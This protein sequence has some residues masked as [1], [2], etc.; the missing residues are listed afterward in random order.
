MKQV[1]LLIALSLISAFG[2]AQDFQLDKDDDGPDFKRWDCIVDF[3]RGGSEAYMFNLSGIYGINFAG[4]HLFYGGGLSASYV[5]RP[6]ESFNYVG[7]FW[8]NG[9]EVR[10]NMTEVTSAGLSHGL[11]SLLMNFR[12][13]ILVRSQW[14]PILQFRMANAFGSRDTYLNQNIGFCYKFRNG[15]LLNFTVGVMNYNHR[16]KLDDYDDFALLNLNMGIK[17]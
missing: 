9:Q 7:K 16:I 12:Y 13:Q 6:E 2:M 15:K 11:V 4:G 1:F 5:F 17:F 10:R 8:E 14:S 3:E